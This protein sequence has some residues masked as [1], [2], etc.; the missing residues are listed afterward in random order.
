MPRPTPISRPLSHKQGAVAPRYYG[1]GLVAW[2]ARSP[3]VTRRPHRSS[4]RRSSVCSAATRPSPRYSSRPATRTGTRC[5]TPR[6]PS[7]ARLIAALDRHGVAAVSHLLPQGTP[8]A[9]AATRI[10]AAFRTLVDGLAAPGTLVAAGGETLRGLCMALGAT[11]LEVQ[12][13]VMP[14]VPVSRL[15]GGRWDG[16]AVVSKS[17]AFGHPTLLRDLLRIPDLEGQ[18]HDPHLA[19]PCRATPSS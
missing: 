18:L 13:S 17:G 11:N 19:I 6:P 7:I 12:G 8:R 4:R 10:E 16:V 9:E 1:A 14:G 2:R 5:R 3:V 15:R